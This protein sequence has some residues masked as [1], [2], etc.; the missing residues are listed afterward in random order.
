[1]DAWKLR[2]VVHGLLAEDAA[3]GINAMI[4]RISGDTRITWQVSRKAIREAKESV[5]SAQSKTAAAEMAELETGGGE[6]A[7]TPR[8]MVTEERH[9]EPEAHWGEAMAAPH[10]AAKVQLSSALGKALKR[11]SKGAPKIR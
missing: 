4:K 5:L 3:M 9:P 2:D 6:D 10:G 7:V 8:E 1:M 11:I